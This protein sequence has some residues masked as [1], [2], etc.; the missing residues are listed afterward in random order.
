[1]FGSSRNNP[2]RPTTT[3]DTLIG[4]KT[5]IKGDISFSGGFRVDGSVVGTIVSDGGADAVE[6]DRQPFGVGPHAGNPNRR[7][8]ID[9]D[10]RLLSLCQ[11][12]AE[13]KHERA[14]DCE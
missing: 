8:R 7:H 2:S 6:I 10:G 4:A 9:N 11:T 14:Q 3:I 13:Q 1:M 5:R 12:A